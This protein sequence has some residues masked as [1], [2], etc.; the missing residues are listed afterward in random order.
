MTAGPC[1]FSKQL[2]VWYNFFSVFEENS[3]RFG[4]IVITIVAE[5]RVLF[6][7]RKKL[8]HTKLL[9]LLSSSLGPRISRSK[10]A[11]IRHIGPQVPPNQRRRGEQGMGKRE[12]GDGRGTGNGWHATPMTR[13]REEGQGKWLGGPEP[14]VPPRAPRP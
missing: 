11:P 8:Y 3:L 12:K 4:P 14:Y 2:F 13:Y 9:L 7:N 5:R 10:V 1:R 6:K